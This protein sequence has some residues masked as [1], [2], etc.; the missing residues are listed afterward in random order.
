VRTRHLRL[1]TQEHSDTVSENSPALS[2]FGP[3]RAGL[4]TSQITNEARL[5]E[6]LNSLE[7]KIADLNTKSFT[8]LDTLVIAT[9]GARVALSA[10]VTDEAGI[11]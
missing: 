5:T 9:E 11:N 3:V 7:R 10:I 2:P 1:V 6:L 4:T 8:V